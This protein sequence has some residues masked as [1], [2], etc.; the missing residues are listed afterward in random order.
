MRCIW[1]ILLG[2][3]C[4]WL[5]LGAN[6]GLVVLFCGYEYLQYRYLS[7][8]DMKDDSYLDVKETAIA[9]AISGIVKM[10]LGVI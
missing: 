4:P 9:Y 10:I 6:L 2:A 7:R 1:H 5:P 8:R 3:V